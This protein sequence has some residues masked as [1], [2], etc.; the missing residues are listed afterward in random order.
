[1]HMPVVGMLFET[2]TQRAITLRHGHVPPQ[3]HICTV[4][5][6]AKCRIISQSFSFSRVIFIL[7]VGVSIPDDEAPASYPSDVN[8]PGSILC[9]PEHIAG[10][11][12][13]QS[14][15]PTPNNPLYGEH[16]CRRRRDDDESRVD[17]ILESLVKSH[18]KSRSKSSGI[19]SE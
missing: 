9:R 12:D 15:G 5:Y 8:S 7:S 2:A 6:I 14:N 4:T 11:V 3:F 19:L 18:E 17:A 13:H 10:N 1:M 16:R